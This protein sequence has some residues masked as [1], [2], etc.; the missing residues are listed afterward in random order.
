[1][2]GDSEDAHLFLNRCYREELPRASSFQEQLVLGQK[3]H[4][5]TAYPQ[6]MVQAK[7]IG[8]CY[9]KQSEQIAM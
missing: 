1:M 2:T 7:F 5:V 6:S 4:S 9:H 8:Q 3:V